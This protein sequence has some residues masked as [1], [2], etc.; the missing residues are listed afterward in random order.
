M[1]CDMSFKKLIKMQENQNYIICPVCGELM[2]R[3]P[4]GLYNGQFSHYLA[5]TKPHYSRYGKKIIDSP[6]NGIYTCCV[7]CNNAVQ[8]NSKS[9]PVTADKLAD[10]IE[11]KNKGSI[12]VLRMCKK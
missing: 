5:K 12:P 11:S 7:G 1:R 2:P 9:E 3:H 6:F 10:W 4:S 8:V